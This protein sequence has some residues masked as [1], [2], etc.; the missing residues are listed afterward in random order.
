V[1]GRT[2]G[3]KT[4]HHPEVG[5]FTLGYQTMQLEG[6]PG[7]RLNAYYAE[8]GTLGHDAMILLDLAAHERAPHPP[9][10]AALTSLRERA[11]R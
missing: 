4:Y 11:R 9:Q 1:K 6:T 5:T 8:P 10:S 2:Y 7:Q 3:H